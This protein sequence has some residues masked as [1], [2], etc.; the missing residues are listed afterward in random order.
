M[1]SLHLTYKKKKINFAFTQPP[2]Q[3]DKVPTILNLH[4]RLDLVI[5]LITQLL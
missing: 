2:I 3:E 5:K 4:I 1:H